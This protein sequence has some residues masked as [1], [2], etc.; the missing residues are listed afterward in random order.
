MPGALGRLRAKGR[1]QD[2]AANLESQGS[3]PSRSWERGLPAPFLPEPSS[4]IS[5]FSL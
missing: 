1:A 4:Y 2:A 3:A 5:P